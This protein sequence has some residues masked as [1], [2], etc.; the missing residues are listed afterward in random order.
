MLKKVG[1]LN[2]ETSTY[3]LNQKK[4]Q[5]WFG[6]TFCLEQQK[7]IHYRCMQGGLLLAVKNMLSTFGLEKINLFNKWMS[8]ISLKI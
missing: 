8:P 4:G 3:P 5:F 1:I 7:Y 2:L 6:K